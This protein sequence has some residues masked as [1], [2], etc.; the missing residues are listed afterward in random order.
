MAKATYVVVEHAGQ[1]DET[2]VPREFKSLGEA[3]KYV[4]RKYSPEQRILLSVDIML[5]CP[6]GTLTTEF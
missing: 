6:D 3:D 2:V 4:R 1:D 5:K